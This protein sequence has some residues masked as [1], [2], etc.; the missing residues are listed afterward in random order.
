MSLIRGALGIA[1]LNLA[2]RNGA[3]ET[4]ANARMLAT[5][6]AGER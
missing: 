1:L 2:S 6:L 3:R 4:C 5:R